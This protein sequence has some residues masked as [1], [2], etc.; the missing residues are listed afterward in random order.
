MEDE[1]LM[2][3]RLITIA[4]DIILLKIPENRYADV[5][6][7]MWDAM[8]TKDIWDMDEI[9]DSK[10]MFKGI[11]LREINMGLIIGRV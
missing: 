2:T 1:Q 7:Q 4:G 8:R 9:I 10:I 6:E 11:K 3:E 5:M